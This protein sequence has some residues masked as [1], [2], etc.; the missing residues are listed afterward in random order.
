MAALVAQTTP[1][2]WIEAGSYDASDLRGLLDVS[3][4]QGVG[5]AADLKVTER[6]AGTNLSVDVSAGSVAIDGDSPSGS[7]KYLCE[8]AGVTNLDIAAA[9]GTGSR[10]D[11]VIARVRD[12]A[13]TGSDDDWVLEVKTGTPGTSPSPPAIPTTSLELA[14][15]TITAG[16]AAITNAMV[17][18]MR[19]S[20][21]RLTV[22]TSTTK[23]AVPVDGQLAT[24]ADT[25]SVFIG[26][27]GAWA[28]ID[29]GGI[30]V[31]DVT[32]GIFGTSPDAPDTYRWK[33][34]A[35]RQ[36]IGFLSGAGQITLPY[37]FTAI[38]Y[39]S[40][41][42]AANTQGIVVN[43]RTSGLPAIAGNVIPLVAFS[44]TDTAFGGT[45]DCSYLV[46]G[47]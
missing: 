13:L 5:S 28:N 37:T 14:R 38:A 35:G 15:V 26:Q 9:P 10:I 29:L 32:S 45:L 27:D 22:A 40:I 25:G 16:T 4:Q 2:L 31:A 23:P 42:P 46:F 1:P 34:I 12:S 39:F 24:E 21:H 20:M 11:S 8:N 43:R 36:S 17:T 19:S 44:T 41:T 18:D 7:H 47:R 33:L 30:D 6:G 3:F